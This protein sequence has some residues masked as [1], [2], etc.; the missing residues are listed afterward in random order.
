M[1]M[2]LKFGFFHFYVPLESDFLPGNII[3]SENH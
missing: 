2:T 3:E 1:S